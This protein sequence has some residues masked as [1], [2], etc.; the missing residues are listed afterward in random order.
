MLFKAYKIYVILSYI[1]LNVKCIVRKIRRAV[2]L[3]PF[4]FIHW[5]FQ[6]FVST[7]LRLWSEILITE[8]ARLPKR[9]ESCFCLVEI[10]HIPLSVRFP[11]RQVEGTVVISWSESPISLVL[12]RQERVLYYYSD[13][14]HRARVWSGKKHVCSTYVGSNISVGFVRVSHVACDR[15]QCG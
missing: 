15:R 12:M 8:P 5:W 9:E 11:G 10:K 13:W 3:D 2:F 1:I 7:A 6:R 14:W 4:D